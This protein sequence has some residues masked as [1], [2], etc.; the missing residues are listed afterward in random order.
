VITPAN[1]KAEFVPEVAEIPC[2]DRDC[3][4]W[5]VLADPY[6][7]IAFIKQFRVSIESAS[8]TSRS[9]SIDIDRNDLYQFLGTKE[10]PPL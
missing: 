3:V 10:A 2:P 6:R 7:L 9:Y 1:G 5:D 8:I 4:R